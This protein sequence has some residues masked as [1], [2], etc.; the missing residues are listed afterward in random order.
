M[1]LIWN[2]LKLIPLP[3]SQREMEKN[4]EMIKSAMLRVVFSRQANIEER[5][6]A[7]IRILHAD[8]E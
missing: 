3:G 4:I 2:D 7:E 8:R 5:R 1:C 6:M